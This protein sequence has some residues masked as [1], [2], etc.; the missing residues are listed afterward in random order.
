M[1]KIL[2]IQIFFKKDKN[3]TIA[4]S[5]KCVI[6][7]SHINANFQFSNSDDVNFENVEV[8]SSYSHSDEYEN[9]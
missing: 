4:E 3:D 1:S 7:E 5:G 6:M 8:Q 9:G 2:F